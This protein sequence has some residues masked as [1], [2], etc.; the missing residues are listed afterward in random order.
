MLASNETNSMESSV[1]ASDPSAYKEELS[2]G[3]HM[4]NEENERNNDIQ[5]PPEIG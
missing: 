2:R 3:F 4:W 5:N 1:I